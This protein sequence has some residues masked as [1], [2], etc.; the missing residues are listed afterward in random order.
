MTGRK[1][2]LWVNQFA[3][4]PHDGGGTRHF[5]VGRELAAL[6]WDVTIAASDLS[7]QE[8]R[9]TRRSSAQERAPIAET[10]D[11]VRFLWLWSAPYHR[12]NWRRGWNWLTFSRSVLRLAGSEEWDVVIGS[13]PHLFAASAA[14]HLARRL[15]VPFVFEVRDL[16]PESL[17]AAGGRRGPFHFVL[18]RLARR[19]YRQAVPLVGLAKGSGDYL[20]RE[21]GVDPARVVF[22]PNGVD[23]SAFDPQPGAAPA[24]AAADKRTVFVYAGAHGAANG[25]DAVVDAAA[26]LRDRSDLCFRL[27]GDGPE[28]TNLVARAE[29]LS[30][31]NLEFLDPIPKS[32]I[33]G[34]FAQADVGLMI[35]R[36]APLFRFAVSPNKL[37]DY[38]AARLPVLANVPGEVEDMVREADAGIVV[39]AGSARAIADAA[40]VFAA[41]D[42]SWMTQRGDA[43][44]AWVE[45]ER[46]REVLAERLDAALR[47]VV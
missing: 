31:S 27:I 33:P 19:L 3:A 39:A 45:R 14:H 2:L 18:D 42:A 38:F 9:Y 10:V 12:N 23:P 5:E 17:L 26:H 34:A 46:S 36:D 24:E 35:L 21:R 22:V 47:R 29:A 32:E 1:K 11:G 15:A 41:K 44:R 37:F 20:A 43:G 6:G 13:S 7:L 30:L 28:K 4:S 16:W 40:E 25:L 8:R